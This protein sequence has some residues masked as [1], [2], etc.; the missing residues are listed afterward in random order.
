MT[1]DSDR[2]RRDA[3]QRRPRV[4][5]KAPTAHSPQPTAHSPQPTAHSPTYLATY[6]SGL[7]P[8][9][10]ESLAQDLP[11][12]SVLTSD[13]SA[14]LFSTKASS[15]EVV[16][17]GYLRNTFEVLASTP[18]RS[19]DAL[20]KSLTRI[21]ESEQPSTSTR[22]FRIMVHLDGGL[23][24]L[25][26]RSRQRLIEAIK[27][28]Y[29]GS[30][31][32]RGGGVEYWLI[33]RRDAAQVYFARRIDRQIPK[34]QRGELAP[35]L[36]ILLV[37]LTNPTARDVVIDPFGGSGALLIAR[38]KYPS[39]QLIY[40][41]L[42]RDSFATS[43]KRL[44]R[45]RTVI[46]EEDGTVLE[47]VASGKVTTIIADPPWGE[48]GDV[49][50]DSAAFRQAMFGTFAR[51]LDRRTGRVVI[52]VSRSTEIDVAQTAKNGGFVLRS[53]HHILVNGHPASVL[54]LT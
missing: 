40:S 1:N 10:E 31:N 36:A 22:Q 27:C 42:H 2:P 38:A 47:S 6:A 50:I 7:G 13:G 25:P 3:R 28:T 30:F 21:I 14:I 4:V 15:R 48:Y 11:E 45:S 29:G 39:R 37:K 17:L 5:G 43:L 44:P 24:P 18:R 26:P 34:V 23:V 35:E 46:L 12:F 49:G 52:L 8:I 19:L 20:V 9:L 32:A 41:D 54:F 53:V 16:D 51:I 33:G